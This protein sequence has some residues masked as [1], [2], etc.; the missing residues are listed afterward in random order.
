MLRRNSPSSILQLFSVTTP[1]INYFASISMTSL[2]GEPINAMID[3]AG[4][5]AER[6][7]TR[8]FLVPGPAYYVSPAAALPVSTNLQL[9]F[10]PFSPVIP[11]SGRSFS[12]QVTSIVV[13]R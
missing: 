8:A 5:P 3:N 11:K 9:L 2:E 10:D 13:M 1:L 12:G 6:R 7:R 4:E